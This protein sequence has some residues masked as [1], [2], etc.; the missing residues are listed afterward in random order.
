[1]HKIM[2]YNIDLYDRINTFKDDSSNSLD[3]IKIEDNDEIY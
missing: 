2:I 1:M 3:E